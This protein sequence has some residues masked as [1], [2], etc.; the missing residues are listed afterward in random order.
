M[1]GH[2]SPAAAAKLVKDGH[3]SGIEL[4]DDNATFCETCTASKIKCLPFLKECSKPAIIISDVVHLDI[5]GPAQT[6]SLGE[7]RY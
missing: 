7:K 6:T 5:C 2:I 1:L 3:I 4:T